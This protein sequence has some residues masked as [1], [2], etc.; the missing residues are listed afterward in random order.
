MWVRALGAHICNCLDVLCVCAIRHGILAYGW[1][2]T[3]VITA[4]AFPV[5]ALRP[6]LQ[7]SGGP[8]SCFIVVLKQPR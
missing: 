3:K 1:M 4:A 5:A 8:F 6:L 7:Q 2:H